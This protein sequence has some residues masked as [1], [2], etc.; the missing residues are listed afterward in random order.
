MKRISMSSA[1]RLCELCL[2]VSL[3]PSELQFESLRDALYHHPKVLRVLVIP[4]ER[5]PSQVM[6]AVDTALS[7]VLTG[8]EDLSEPMCI[9]EILTDSQLPF[10]FI[11][12]SSTFLHLQGV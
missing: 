7:G 2:D 4:E 12:V 11:I 1:R 9:A 10:L 8:E 3:W 5:D 6:S